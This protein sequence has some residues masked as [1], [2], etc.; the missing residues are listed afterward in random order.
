MPSTVS[1]PAI[2]LSAASPADVDTD[3]LAVPIF[4]ETIRPADLARWTTRR[5]AR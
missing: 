4:E 2:A 3:L 1:L 5:A